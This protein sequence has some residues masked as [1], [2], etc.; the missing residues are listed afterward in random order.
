MTYVLPVPV[1]KSCIDGHQ[2]VP[3]NDFGFQHIA[4]GWDA[5]GRGYLHSELFYNY[6]RYDQSDDR[7][8]RAVI[9]TMLSPAFSIE[10]QHVLP[11]VM[12]DLTHSADGDYLFNS[13]I[14]PMAVTRSGEVAFT[15]SK[16]HTLIF[17]PTFA[18]R[19]ADLR[20]GASDIIPLA[21]GGYVVTRGRDVLAHA[22]PGPVREALAA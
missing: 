22:A 5:A 17:D 4:L 8:L 12:H 10:R 16:N 19:L 3:A 20:D 13:S 7:E 9:V 6:Y 14:T 2:V 11:E 21:D 18:H 15:N 1:P